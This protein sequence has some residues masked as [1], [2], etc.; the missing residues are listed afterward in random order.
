M[1]VLTLG[2]PAIGPFST[3]S[4]QSVHC[5]FLSMWVL[6]GNGI[7]CWGF[8]RM[9]KKSR[10]AS[11]MVACAG[12][13]TVDDTCAGGA[14]HAIAPIAIAAAQ[15]DLKVCTAPAGSRAALGVLVQASRPALRV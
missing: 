14:P 13:K 4:W 3:L 9:A 5:A 11:R 6:C 2:M 1:H 12:V 8:D 7:G 10:A 15:A